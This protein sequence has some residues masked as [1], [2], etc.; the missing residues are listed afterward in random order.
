MKI[1]GSSSDHQNGEKGLK[2]DSDDADIV[3]IGNKK[4]LSTKPEKYIT[5]S[6]RPVDYAR[7]LSRPLV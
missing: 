5:L 3:N 1:S 2:L 7:H 6:G 4:K